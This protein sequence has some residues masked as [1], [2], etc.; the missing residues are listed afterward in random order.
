MKKHFASLFLLLCLT[1]WLLSGHGGWLLPALGLA[2]V[3]LATWLSWR[4]DVVDRESHPLHLSARLIRFWAWLL[5][6]IVVANAQVVRLVLSPRAALRP[7]VLEVATRQRSVLGRV[8]LGNAITLTPGTVTLDLRGNRLLVHALT[9]ASAE[10]VRAGV[11]DRR[12]PGDVEEPI[13]LPPD[14]HPVEPAR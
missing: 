5:R 14:E 2:S 4:M 7:Q 1:W 9:P 8:V 10:D 13:D 3:A 12:V 6:E 11:I